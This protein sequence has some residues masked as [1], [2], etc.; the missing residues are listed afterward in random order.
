MAET[1]VL[2]M[3]RPVQR[4]RE[5]SP[6]FVRNLRTWLV[7]VLYREHGLVNLVELI[8]SLASRKLESS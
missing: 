7:M 6:G 2:A 4:R 5:S 3:R 8:P 1:Y